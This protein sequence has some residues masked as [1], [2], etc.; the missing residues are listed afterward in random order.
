MLL[1][2]MMMMMMMMMT[3]MKVGDASGYCDNGNPDN[4]DGYHG[5]DDGNDKDTE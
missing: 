2:L 1:L 5:T 3:M 4:D